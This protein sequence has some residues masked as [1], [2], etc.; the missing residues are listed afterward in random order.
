MFI[1]YGEIGVFF[2]I[3]IIL[4]IAYRATDKYRQTGRQTGGLADIVYV[5]FF[6]VLVRCIACF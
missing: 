4:D 2:V 6:F 5:S 1:S 3:S